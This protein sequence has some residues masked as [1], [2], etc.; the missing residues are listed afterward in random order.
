[1]PHLKTFETLES[2][3]LWLFSDIIVPSSRLRLREQSVN[4][5]SLLYSFEV[6]LS[7]QQKCSCKRT[8]MNLGS[9]STSQ[10]L[11]LRN[12]AAS[13][14]PRKVCRCCRSSLPQSVTWD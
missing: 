5:C 2:I 11:L 3:C 1:M 8:V 6:S 12:S 10:C 14:M 9:A 4:C 13:W 7:R